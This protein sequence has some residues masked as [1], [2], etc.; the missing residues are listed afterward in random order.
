MVA[1]DPLYDD[2]HPLLVASMI[3]KYL[4]EGKSASA[5]VA[6]KLS[7]RKEHR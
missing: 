6:G 3:R 2:E 7:S 4:K 1:A 5:L